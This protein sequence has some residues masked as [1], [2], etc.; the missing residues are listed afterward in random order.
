MRLLPLLV[1]GCSAAVSGL[2]CGVKSP[3]GPLPETPCTQACCG[4]LLVE[5][6]CQNDVWTCPEGTV[7]IATCN[8]SCTPPPASG[9]VCVDRDAGACL[10]CPAGEHCFSTYQCTE[11]GDGGVTCADTE[12]DGGS[13]DGGLLPDDR[14]YAPCNFFGC[15]SGTSCVRV[16]AV[17]CSREALMNVSLCVPPQ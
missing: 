7:D 3:C 12:W 14:C 5:H 4:D 1:L 13:A 10:G 16:P 2:A 8:T 11:D 9:A 17:S 15:P 6:L